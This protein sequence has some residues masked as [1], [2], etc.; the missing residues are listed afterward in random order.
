MFTKSLT[1]IL[2]SSAA[3]SAQALSFDR[4]GFGFATEALEPGQTVLE[5]SLPNYEN[6]EDQGTVST[7]LGVDGLLRFGLIPNFELQIGT[8][9]YG[10]HSNKAK[11]QAVASLTPSPLACS[12]I[13]GCFPPWISA[14]Q[15]HKQAL[16]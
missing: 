7:K 9:F 11:A 3:L 14:R 8:E 12:W 10:I 13:C 4:P 2:L 1:L 16:A 15:I 5:L 6:N